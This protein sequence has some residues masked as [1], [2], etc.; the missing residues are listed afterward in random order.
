MIFSNKLLILFLLIPIY[1]C[2]EEKCVFI[3]NSESKPQE[4]VVVL[5][6][7][8]L[9]PNNSKSGGIITHWSKF[10]EKKMAISDKEGN[11]CFE[12][13]VDEDSNYKYTS[14]RYWVFSK[15]SYES[16]FSDYSSIPEVVKIVEKNKSLEIN[17]NNI[18]I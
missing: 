4:G 3:V 13:H 14:P 18:R 5:F 16:T 15:G 10:Y 11:A 8:S 7:S 17:F 12:M 9:I 6:R 2:S 1:S